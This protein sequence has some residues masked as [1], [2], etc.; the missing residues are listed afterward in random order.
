M[1]RPCFGKLQPGMG[2]LCGRVVPTGGGKA[3]VWKAFDISW[4][5]KIG[6]LGR[7]CLGKPLMSP[8]MGR[9]G[10]GKSVLNV[11]HGKKYR[12]QALPHKVFDVIVDYYYRQFHCFHSLVITVWP[13]E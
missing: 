7:P 12:A 6:V 5:G 10:A 1:G 8:G 13:A 3:V 2:C 4:D 11:S 9:P